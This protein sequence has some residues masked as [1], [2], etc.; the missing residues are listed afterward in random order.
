MKVCGTITLCRRP[1]RTALCKLERRVLTVRCPPK[2]R[3]GH[4]GS[5][6][7]RSPGMSGLSAGHGT[8]SS[9]LH[10]GLEHPVYNRLT[11]P[12]CSMCAVRNTPHS[13]TILSAA[14]LRARR[15]MEFL[16]VAAETDH[17]L[18][19]I[20]TTPNRAQRLLCQ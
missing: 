20:L 5:N 10:Q 11:E 17:V 19:M 8:G 7:C 2:L 1:K 13:L 6:L 18:A 9:W 3:L 12:V 4:G 14:S 15:Q 16:C